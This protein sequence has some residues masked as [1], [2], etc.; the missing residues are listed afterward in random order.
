MD[1]IFSRE[2]LQT[3]EDI[4]LLVKSASEWQNSVDAYDKSILEQT[5]SLNDSRSLRDSYAERKQKTINKLIEL[6]K[7][8]L[9]SLGKSEVVVII[10]TNNES[11][12]DPLESRSGEEDV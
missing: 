5:R 1:E 7:K 10:P 6:K 4:K 8:L 9:I 12:L 11:A 2:D 3:I